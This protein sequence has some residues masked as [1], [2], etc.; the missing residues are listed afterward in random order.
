MGNALSRLSS[1]QKWLTPCAVFLFSTLARAS[2]GGDYG[3]GPRS[4][5]LAGA[6][7]SWNFDGYSAY[8]NPAGLPLIN[9][10]GTGFP[11]ERFSFSYGLVYMAPSFSPIDNVITA[12]SYTYGPMTPSATSGSVDTAYKSS[13]GQILGGSWIADPE[14]KNFTLGFTVF[15]PLNSLAY[16]DTGPTLQPEYV[17]YRDRNQQP[18]IALAGG[19]ELTPTFRVGAGLRVDY[20]LSAESDA[21]L[22]LTNQGASSAQLATSI[23]PKL[24]PYFGFQFSK[25][26]RYSI[27]FVTRFPSAV[28]SSLTINSAF[29]ALPGVNTVP[30]S[31]G[32]QDTLVYQPL[33]LELGGSYQTSPKARSYAQLDFQSWSH[34]KAPYLLLGNACSGAGCGVVISG[35]PT[36]E[37]EY[38]DILI[39]R[40]GEEITLRNNST[41]RLG[42]AYRPGIFR[43]TP[44]GIGNYL[45]PSK[46][47][48]NVGMG[49][50]YNR[51]L[52]YRKPW[53]LDVSLNYQGMVSQSVTKTTG[54]ENG[55]P[56]SQKIGAPGYQTGGHVLGGQLSLTLGI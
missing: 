13:F 28:T 19:L 15:F 31:F 21:T 14:W 17:L 11:S 9:R 53:N 45:D 55:T 56:S 39:P 54:D 33:S 35:G 5:S 50:V 6:S 36:I 41:L 25:E 24:T 7:S 40:I 34:F 20:T 42:Y 52:G 26:D 23:K 4:A 16:I 1:K 37:A 38:R 18:E 8:N 51:F 47:L 10:S 12:N 22:L 27:G 44:G 32:A 46:H 30:V 29:Q 3:F 43:S 49:F 48:L 2:I